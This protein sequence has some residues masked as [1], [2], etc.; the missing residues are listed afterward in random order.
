MSGFTGAFRPLLPY[1]HTQRLV[2]CDLLDA[3]RSVYMLKQRLLRYS[4]QPTFTYLKLIVFDVIQARFPFM[5]KC[6]L[7]NVVPKAKLLL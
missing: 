5:F 4:L 6:V 3:R 7:V 2:V 1:L